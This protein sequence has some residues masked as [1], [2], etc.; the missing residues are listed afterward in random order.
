MTLHTGTPVGFG[1]PVAPGRNQ[2]NSCWN[3]VGAATTAA[4]NLCNLQAIVVL[5]SHGENGFGAFTTQGGKLPAPTEASEI[6]NT[7]NDQTFVKSDS[8]GAGFDDV[9]FA[10]S[11]DDLLE[12]L[13][14]R[15]T[16]KSGAVSSIEAVRTSAIAISNAIVNSAALCTPL[17]PCTSNVVANVPAAPAG[18]PYTV[19]GVALPN[20]VWGSSLIYAPSIPNATI[21]TSNICDSTVPGGTTAFTVTSTGVD[22]TP[23]SNANT[24]VNDDYVISVTV[25][26][27]RNQIATRYGSCG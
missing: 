4:E 15:N 3:N 21:A 18:P 6:E 2:L 20:D 14:R 22:A 10:W 16:V 1:L 12:P 11:P 27:M 26:Q 9:V 19:L 8:T 7:N 25:D 5:I 13:Y 23:G 24:G 17:P